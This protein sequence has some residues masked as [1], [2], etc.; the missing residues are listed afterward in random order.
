MWSFSSQRNKIDLRGGTKRNE[1]ISLY[2]HNADREVSICDLLSIKFDN[3]KLE[4]KL[5]C[6][7]CNTFY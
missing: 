2:Y 1:K 5:I 6:Y 7:F 3:K 4:L